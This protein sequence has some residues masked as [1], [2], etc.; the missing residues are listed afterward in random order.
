MSFRSAVASLLRNLGLSQTPSEGMQTTLEIEAREE[1]RAARRALNPEVLK[2][3]GTAFNRAARRLAKKN[4]IPLSL[5]QTMQQNDVVVARE[6]R[7]NKRKIQWFI[8][9]QSRAAKGMR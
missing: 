5:L 7:I 4:G 9:A 2:I 3:P 8:A 6:R 1:R